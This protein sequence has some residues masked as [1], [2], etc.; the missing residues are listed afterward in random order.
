[1][2]RAANQHRAI[3]ENLRIQFLEIY[4]VQR[5]ERGVLLSTKIGVLFAS[6]LSLCAPVI[7]GRYTWK[8]GVPVIIAFVS[9]Q[10]NF[11][12]KT[13]FPFLKML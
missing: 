2:D 3:L 1:M 12:L 9:F 5:F 8:V 6:V 11:L 7:T 13:I 4:A 10:V